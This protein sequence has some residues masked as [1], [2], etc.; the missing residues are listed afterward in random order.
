MTIS[1]KCAP[2]EVRRFAGLAFDRVRLMGIVN[3]TADSFSDGGETLTTEDAVARGLTMLEEGADIVDVGGE[4]TRPGALPVPVE[5]EGRRV[6]P[7]VRALARAGALVSVDTRRAEVMRAAIDEGARIINDITALSDPEALPLIVRTDVSVVLM[8]MQGEPRT[9]QQNP[10]YDDAA[11]EVYT[12]LAA[13]GAACGEAGIAAERIAV[14]PGIGFGKTLAH[15]LAIL[16]DLARYRDL[17]YALLVG[18]SRKRFI[19][20]IDRDQPPQRR[21][22]GSLA[23]AIACA[24]AGADIV[25]VHDVGETRQALAV[26]RSLQ[27]CHV[28][29]RE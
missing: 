7:V 23:A 15:N 6:L 9:M 29:R 18:V 21:L 24:E 1:P 4:S 10:R 12:W 16:G 26:H 8:H 2:P 25:R 13:R 19:T 22:A 28:S 17:P 14:D 3:V 20:A 5:I 27:K 11:A